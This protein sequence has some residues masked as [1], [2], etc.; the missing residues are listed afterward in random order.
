MYVIEPRASF[1]M[2]QH[3]SVLVVNASGQR[4]CLGVALMQIGND[5]KLQLW[6]SVN[7]G[8][9]LQIHGHMVVRAA[10]LDR[11]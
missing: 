8:C 5:L 7:T 6:R 9:R 3:E 11:Q 1:A 10:G 2:C 4:L